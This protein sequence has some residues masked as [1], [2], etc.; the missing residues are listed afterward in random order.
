MNTTN[1][2]TSQSPSRPV[3]AA[4]A[5]PPRV[6]IVPLKIGWFGPQGSGKTTTAA[7]LSMALSKEVYGGA[8]VCVTDTEPGWQFLRPYFALE[9][10]EL[11]QFTDPTFKAMTRNLRDA[12]EKHGA[13]VW[14]VDTLTILWLELMQ[15][16]KGRNGGYIPI[17]KWGDI[18]EMWNKDYVSLFQNTSMCCQALGR[19]GNVMDEIQDE[20]DP[21][22]TKTVKTGTRFKAGGGEDFG[23]EPH[24]LLEMSTERK[25]K[26]KQGV[27]REGEGR[28]IHR[29]DVLKDRTWAMN[30]KVLRFSDKPQ[31]QKG[32]YRQ[33]WDAIKPH[34][35][36][37]Q[38]TAH[39]RIET[40]TSSQELIAVAGDSAYYERRRD[41]QIELEIIERTIAVMWPGQ[42]TDAKEMRHYMVEILF[43]TRSWTYVTSRSLEDLRAA[44]QLLEVFERQLPANPK[45]RDDK[46]AAQALLNRCR[47][48]VSVPDV[49]IAPPID[50]PP[51]SVYESAPVAT[52]ATP[53]A[54]A[55]KR[56]ARSSRRH[57]LEDPELISP[58]ES[59]LLVK[60]ATMRGWTTPE[61]VSALL[62][63]KGITG[64]DCIPI[65][66][67][68][69]VCEMIEAGVESSLPSSQMED[70]RAVVLEGVQPSS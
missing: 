55:P 35:D 58:R 12:Q 36:A 39:V 47:Q 28:M 44:R 27:E 63:I 50:E 15:S 59:M 20:N 13:C 45:A 26:R 25:A 34:W 33:V 3:V 57:H 52:D 16:F 4:S 21:N 30:G 1:S 70:K 51:L 46:D 41:V 53:E 56:R 10:I 32:G 38:A 40:Q 11:I 29:A 66:R 60:M 2:P 43:G 42:S 22:R 19:L 48:F 49:E 24:L 37:V 14:N 65:D 61:F 7:L 9:G 64:P 54:P 67:Y 62:Q 8:P 68:E 69:E 23:Y 6:D 18:R 31:Y 17:D 5:I